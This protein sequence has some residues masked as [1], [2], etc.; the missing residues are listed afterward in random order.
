MPRAGYGRLDDVLADADAVRDR[1][2]AAMSRAFAEHGI[3]GSA[4][5]DS[6]LDPP[7]PAEEAA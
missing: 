5:A 6:E 4:I 2:R 7:S 3:G 1:L